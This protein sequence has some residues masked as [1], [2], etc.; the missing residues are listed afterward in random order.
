MG[1]QKVAGMGVGLQRNLINST[2]AEKRAVSLI[3]VYKDRG[4][5]QSFRGKIGVGQGI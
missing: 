2:E 5:L 3:V 4:G 1:I